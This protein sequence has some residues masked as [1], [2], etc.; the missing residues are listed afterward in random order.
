MFCLAGQS[1]THTVYPDLPGVIVKN[2]L[3]RSKPDT[4]KIFPFSCSLSQIYENN[5]HIVVIMNPPD[6]K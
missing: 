2:W 3:R 1:D 4:M 6:I 5:Q